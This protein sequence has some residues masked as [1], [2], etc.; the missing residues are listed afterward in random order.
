VFFV[1]CVVEFDRS[2][3]GVECDDTLVCHEEFLLCWMC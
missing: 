1:A 2:K 3:E